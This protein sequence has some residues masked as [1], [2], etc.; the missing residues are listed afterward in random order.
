MLYA[1][2]FGPTSTPVVAGSEMQ[3]GE[4]HANARCHHRR[5]QCYSGLRGTGFTRS[6]SN[7]TWLFQPPRR[8]ATCNTITATYNGVSAAPPTALITV[9]GSRRFAP[10]TVTLYVAPNGNNFWS[11]RFAAPNSTNTDGPLATFDRARAI[12]QQINKS[13]LTQVNV[14]FRAGNVRPSCNRNV[15]GSRLRLA[16]ATDRLSK[17]LPGESPVISG[18]ARLQNWT[19]AS[20]NT[21]KTTLPTSTQ[22]F[23][24]L[25]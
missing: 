23:E 10:T 22:Y 19:N 17:L 21:W 1:N 2:G 13:G 25:F 24:N 4:S 14:E 12:V 20:G 5:D 8:A 16:H 18:G 7:S 15:H 3:G 11:G 6:C 9:Q